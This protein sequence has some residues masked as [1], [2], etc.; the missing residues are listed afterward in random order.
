[1]A[2]VDQVDRVDPQRQ[3]V[4]V[5]EDTT[6]VSR[7]NLALRALQAA[8]ALQVDQVKFFFYFL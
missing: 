7:D 5:V 3:V 8:L 4:V 1:M 2:Q 6:L